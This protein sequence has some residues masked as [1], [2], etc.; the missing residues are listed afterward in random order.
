MIQS[1]DIFCVIETKTDETDII[2]LQ[3][4][5]YFSQCRKQSFVRKS[6]GIGI[7]VKNELAK[8]ISVI[9]S[10]SDY[11]CWFKLDK[12]CLNI[13]EDMHFGAVYTPPSDSRFNTQ[14]E[15]DMFEVEISSMCISHKYV[16]LLGDFNARIQTK[17]DF[18]DVDDFFA[19]HFN[20]DE[21]L[22]QFYNISSL[23]E[24]FN[25][26]KFRASKDK[27]AN[28]EGNILLETCKSNN[29]FILNGR[30]GKDKNVGAFTFKQCSVIDYI[31]VSS[32]ALKFV[33]N[34]E[35]QELD[36][37]Y[38]DGHAL[39]QTALKFKNIQR[40]MPHVKQK[41]PQPRSQWKNDKKTDFVINLDS[42]KLDELSSYL[43]QVQR[44][45]ENITKD[46]SN[47]IC[48]KI[49]AIFIDSA[50]KS[51]PGQSSRNNDDKTTHKRWF[52]TKCQSA[53]KKYHLAR[54]IN[55]LTPSS[56]NKQN[57]KEAS[58]HYKRTMNFHI[59]KF[60][61]DT[62]EKLRKLK[63]DSPK[64]FWKLINNL[65][66]DKGDQN[67]SLESLYTFFKDLNTSNEQ[68]DD[69]IF[70][71]IDI[72]D[73]DEFL[74][75]SITEAEIRKCIK[76]LKNNKCPAND[77]ILNEYLKCSSDKLIPIYIS[78]FNVILD[79]GI[80]PDSWLEGIIRPIYKLGGDPTQPENYRPIT[81]LSCFGKLFTAILN[82]RL[83]SFIDHHDI[84]NE[85]QAG[86]RSGYST[87]D[88]I[89]TLHILSEILKHNKKK[90]FCSFIDFSK[91]FDSVW[92]LGLWMKLLSNNINGKIF[93][94]INNMYKDIKSCVM[95]SGEQSCFFKSQIGVRQGENL[96]PILFS[97]FLNDL[98]DYM[99]SNGCNGFEF[100]MEDNQLNAYLKLMVLLYADDTVIFG[101]D[102]EN[103]QN[104]LNVFFEY[105]Q[106]WK[107]N[108]NYHKT[109]VLI[110]GARNTANFEFK[111]GNM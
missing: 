16:L 13:D 26:T 27:T 109:K 44:N 88:H 39:L 84:L 60:N 23:L 76:A 34:F 54:R 14:D 104:N 12:S 25:M 110:F 99:S 7:F 95:H 73:D 11:I 85:N 83:N 46:N 80:I 63:T 37:L 72:S 108:I 1:Y 36:S 31:I 22:R 111:L 74:N 89:F 75:S 77:R 103:F 61:R 106:Q 94:I 107:L 100:N 71:N 32:Q 15:M 53:R 58:Q 42:H 20:F 17:E 56:I 67:I 9:E 18:L 97:L 82:S 102:A 52:G 98:E 40:N 81:I 93:R 35:I 6:G 91:A 33:C 2:S 69:E 66:R 50:D 29:L 38:T 87:T 43:E 59:N 86:F 79:T 45:T 57:L 5:T 4:Y 62:Q 101:T 65:E 78:L 96:S 24:N 28:N 90:L 48:S 64:D 47:D 21:S 92:R 10:D 105:T 3:N 19:E 41:S 70:A 51:F 55:R 68:P 30:C 8:Y 49:S